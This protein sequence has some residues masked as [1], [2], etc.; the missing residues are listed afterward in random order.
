MSTLEESKTIEALTEATSSKTLDDDNI[1]LLDLEDDVPEEPLPL[2]PD[3]PWLKEWVTDMRLEWLRQ[4]VSIGLNIPRSIFNTVVQTEEGSNQLRSFLDGSSSCLLFYLDEIVTIVE[5]I[6]ELPPPPL[7]PRSED[8]A[9]KEK[10]EEEEDNA[11]VDAS[12]AKEDAKEQKGK[13]KKKDRKGDKKGE[14]KGDKKDDKK[15]KRGGKKG[16][17]ESTLEL[18]QDVDNL[19]GEKSEGDEGEGSEGGNVPKEPQKVEEPPKPQIIYTQKRDP[20]LCASIGLLP[21]HALSANVA[22]FLKMTTIDG[23]TEEQLYHNVEF[24]ILPGGPGLSSL[25]KVIKIYLTSIVFHHN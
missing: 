4:K 2:P 6:V 5:T 9:S 24:G 11:R 12:K 7:S 15:G 1:I 17:D 22:Y 21:K 3:K 25:E 19:E 14:K 8:V 20:I 23:I 10:Q 13:D 16:K 18:D